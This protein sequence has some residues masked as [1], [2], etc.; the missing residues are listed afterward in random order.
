MTE[1]KSQ[2]QPDSSWVLEGGRICVTTVAANEMHLVAGILD[3]AAGWL[4]SRGLPAWP[5]PFPVDWIQAGISLGTCY[6]AWDGP[7]PVGTFTLQRTDPAFW[8]ERRDEPADYALYLHRFAVLRSHRGLGRVLLEFAQGLTQR[9]GA[10]CLRLDCVAA[11]PGIRR[12]YE[13]AG[14]KHRGD[15]D[16]TRGGPWTAS[17]YE[18]PLA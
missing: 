9:S 3:E 8:G 4:E 14:F 12:Y 18:K 17:L 6:L 13:A 16:V 11:N 2:S 7:T 5:R 10:S 15:I 1:P